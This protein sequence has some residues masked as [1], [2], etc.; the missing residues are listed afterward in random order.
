[1]LL[2]NRKQ[3]GYIECKKVM[4]KFYSIDEVADLISVSADTIREWVSEGKL[5][6]S[7]RAGE[8]VLRSAE[9]QKLL[10]KYSVPHE[11]GMANAKTGGAQGGYLGGNPSD[12]GEDPASYYGYENFGYGDDTPAFAPPDI[13]AK[14]GAKAM[15]AAAEENG[16]EEEAQQ[17][18]LPP[19]APNV[20]RSKFD[21]LGQSA[22]S[23]DISLD[24]DSLYDADADEYELQ[25]RFSMMEKPLAEKSEICG[26][27]V[28][29]KG[30]AVRNGESKKSETPDFERVLNKT[31]EPIMRAQARVIKLLNESR[32]EAPVTSLPI[33]APNSSDKML[34]RIEEKLNALKTD[35]EAVRADSG[36]REELLSLRGFIEESLAKM[37]PSEPSPD[38]EPADGIVGK[39][40]LEALQ[41]T[42]RKDLDVIRTDINRISLGG[43]ENVERFKEL[44]S[45][46]DGLQKKYDLLLQ[47][48]NNVRLEHERFVAEHA[49]F[50]AKNNVNAILDRLEALREPLDAH[51]LSNEDFAQKIVDHVEELK[52]YIETLEGRYEAC[53]EETS[54]LQLMIDK[55]QSENGRLKDENKSF[56]R[57]VEE[58]GA[59]GKDYDKLKAEYEELKEVSDTSKE[60]YLKLQEQYLVLKDRNQKLS[61][62]YQEKNSEADRLQEELAAL[63]AASSSSGA[64]MDELESMVEEAARSEQEALAKIEELEAQL[65]ELSEANEE[66]EAKAS[67]AEAESIKYKEELEECQARLKALDEAQTEAAAGSDAALQEAQQ[68]IASLQEQLQQ[69]RE[70]VAQISSESALF[71]SNM[72]AEKTRLLRMVNSLQAKNEDL[73]AQLKGSGSGSAAKFEDDEMRRQLEELQAELLDTKERLQDAEQRLAEEPDGGELVEL[74][75]QNEELRE[76]IE[77]LRYELDNKEAASE[78]ETPEDLMAELQALEAESEVKDRMLEDARQE[79]S[80][81][82]EELDRLKK[83]L[84]EQQQL[85]EREHKE[86]SEIVKKQVRGEEVTTSQDSGRGGF[87]LFKNRSSN[88]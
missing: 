58:L 67:E 74:T 37:A 55:L 20:V 39:T 46:L 18:F 52:I 26:N 40:D 17:E 68:E 53:E 24:Y 59:S 84:F 71:S 65:A 72:E 86:W 22:G 30:G 3:G 41:E 82:R 8:M 11:S 49:E 73:T 79:T 87:R 47:K 78:F 16:A 1:M 29:V 57:Q 13:A 56:S 35:A 61:D 32:R 14:A 21:V 12:A 10:E 64:Q 85:Y 4:S 50:A 42:L 63:R 77:A 15:A 27:F 76:E 88:L 44:E 80:G 83:A 45:N 36:V 5:T 7:R 70:T 81:L 43:E 38:K 2:P 48:Y 33:P 9:V 60:T 6:A 66:S 62:D 51:S 25:K 31:L 54:T 19:R 34:L 69:Q 75:A 23:A 28:S